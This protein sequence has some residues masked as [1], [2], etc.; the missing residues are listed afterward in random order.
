MPEREKG[1]NFS[2]ERISCMG[3]EFKRLRRYNATWTLIRAVI[4]G[5]SVF[6]LTSGI[7]LL[8]D[9]LEIV[10]LGVVGFLVGL[11]AGLATAGVVCWLLRKSDLLLAEKIDQEQKLRERVQ[12]MVAYRDDEGAVAQLQRADTENRLKQVRKVGVKFQGVA[13]H[14]L[15][16]A[17]GFV[18]FMVGL[19]LPAEAVQEGPTTQT[20]PTEPLYEVTIW[21]KAALEELIVHV[22]ASEMEDAVKTP[23][24]EDL[25]QLRQLLETPLRVSVLQAKV[26][27]SM[28]LAYTLMDAANSNDDMHKVLSMMSHKMS[29]YLCYCLGNL[30]LE[31]Y[32]EKMDMAETLLK[33]DNYAAIGAVSGEVLAVLKFSEYDSSD[34]L[35]AAV[36]TFGNELG[37]A[38]AALANSNLI[39]ARQM[40]GEAMY[41]LRSNA[42]LALQ[43]QWLNKEEA[44]YVVN[45]LA[46]IFSISSSSIPKD[47]DREFELDTSEP[48]PEVGGSQ[49]T[50]EMQYPSDDKVYDYQNNMHVIYHQIL[51][52]YYKSM[53]NDAMDGKFSEEIEAF[54]RQY[55]GN[56]QTKQDEEE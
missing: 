34:A 10:R 14:M 3:S 22:Q 49:G 48:P 55:F 11:V 31:D 56:L 8:L 1:R 4:L 6:L 15:A 30:A 52:E 23:M 50:G 54:L 26:I 27:D 17:V 29:A 41:N 9:K 44:L 32:D 24:V 39:G 13:V 33:Q 7:F 21:Q 12:T 19:M 28:N 43:Q 47:P 45:T 20:Q 18:V 36:E 25:T 37:A 16:L 2:E 35:Y 53:T 38:A 42:S 51:E 5:A 40:A 46:E